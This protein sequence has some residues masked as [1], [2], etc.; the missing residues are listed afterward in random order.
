[1]E[2]NAQ[3]M[4]QHSKLY[5][6]QTTLAAAQ[7]ILARNKAKTEEQKATAATNAENAR[8]ELGLSASL[9]P[10]IEG[11]PGDQAWKDTQR[12]IATSNF[13]GA[14]A[15][16]PDKDR[17][18]LVT[19]MSQLLQM[20]DPKMQQ[21][22]AA[23]GI[24]KLYHDTPQGATSFSPVPGMPTVEGGFTLGQGQQRF[25]SNISSSFSEALG[26]NPMQLEPIAKVA[27][28]AANA[29]ALQPGRTISPLVQLLHIMTD[30][31]ITHTPEEKA[32]AAKLSE[33]LYGTGTNL[34]SGG[35]TGA[36]IAL[37]PPAEDALDL[38]ATKDLMQKGKKYKTKNGIA[39]WDGDHFVQ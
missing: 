39:T 26:S 38:P 7:E 13:A 33:M 14:M 20:H 35:L 32:K 25:P 1:M 30:P 36:P 6:A 18:K 28:K 27:P 31:T 21:I 2:N 15:Q 29:A 12:T 5:D 19:N 34:L 11:G 23:G 22:M 8:R 16:L 17:S 4:R 3:L 24:D 37:A 10:M 9:M